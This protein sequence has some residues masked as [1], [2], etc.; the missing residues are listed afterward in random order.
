MAFIRYRTDSRS[1]RLFLCHS[2]RRREYSR[3]ALGPELYHTERRA[4]SPPGRC[5]GKC[6]GTNPSTVTTTTP[7]GTAGGGGN[8]SAI[9]WRY[10]RAARRRS[11]G[12]GV[13]SRAVD[14]CFCFVFCFFETCASS[15]RAAGAR[16]GARRACATA[17]RR[18]CPAR[19]ARPAGS[20]GTGRPSSCSSSAAPSTRG[21]APRP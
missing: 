9:T 21:R 18:R 2:P 3:G 12:G 10:P 11:Q 8:T 7:G 4:V 13:Q 6:L 16:S 15:Q 19:A 20:S 14:F 5:L 1:R 17:A